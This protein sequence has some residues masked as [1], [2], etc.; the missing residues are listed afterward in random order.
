MLRAANA[1]FPDAVGPTTKP[2]R[3]LDQPLGVVER[4]AEVGDVGLHHRIVESL[5][6]VGAVEH[7]SAHRKASVGVHLPADRIHRSEVVARE[8]RLL[9]LLTALGAHFSLKATALLNA[10]VQDY[11][12]T[13]GR[14]TVGKSLALAGKIVSFVGL[15]LTFVSVMLFVI[16]MIV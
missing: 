10:Y 13:D 3:P 4:E 8:D 14:A 7:H 5:A 15:G 2:L 16:L 12:E 9:S 1:V 6:T 11:G